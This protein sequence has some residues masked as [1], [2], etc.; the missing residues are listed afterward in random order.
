MS[1]SCPCCKAINQ[2]SPCRRCKADL[3]FLIEFLEQ[4]RR[5]ARTQAVA[6]LLRG[7]YQEAFAHYA[8]AKT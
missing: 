3:K 4:Q 5:S 6:A 7:D 1:I 8:K 2:E